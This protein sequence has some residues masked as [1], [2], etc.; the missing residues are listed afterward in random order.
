MEINFEDQNLK[1]LYVYT[2]IVKENEKEEINFIILEKNAYKYLYIS[3]ES[4]HPSL[5]FL[6][7]TVLTQ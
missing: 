3:R 4:A 1:R 2:Y 6:K 5:H 7:I